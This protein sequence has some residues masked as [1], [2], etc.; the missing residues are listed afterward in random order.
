MENAEQAIRDLIEQNRVLSQQQSDL[1]ARF[2]Q[3]GA[4]IQQ[5]QTE[6]QQQRAADVRVRGVGDRPVGGIDTRNLGKPEI[7]NGEAAK[8]RDWSL[9]L[10]SY[11]SAVDHN[12]VALMNRAE[13]SPNPVLNL[14]LDAAAAAISAQLYYVLVMTCRGTA[15]DRVV[16]AGH[17]EGLEAWRQLQLANDPRTGTRH[18]GML[19]E[20]LSYSFEGDVL[21]RLEA[22][23]RDLA[24][25]ETS[26]G[27]RMPAG[28]KIGTVVRQSPEGALRQ[29]LIMNMDRFQTWEAFKHEIQNVKRAQA[30]AQS[31]PMPMNIDSLQQADPEALQGIANQLLSLAKGKGKTK[32]KKG[33]GKGK[34]KGNQSGS[35]CPICNRSGHTRSE[36][37]Y[38]TAGQSHPQ[39]S[40]SKGKGKGGGGKGK[41]KG[42]DSRQCWTCGQAG[43]VASQCP[44]RGSNL[45]QVGY[46][47]G[48]QN[49]Y[50]SPQQ[51]AQQQQPDP[52]A[53]NPLPYA[54][55][56]PPYIQHAGNPLHAV[57][58]H[59]ASPQAASP[60]H[61]AATPPGMNYAHTYAPSTQGLYLTSLDRD[62]AIMGS[63]MPAGG[64]PG[65][66]SDPRGGQRFSI[67]IDSGAAAS[68]LPSALCSDY[69]VNRLAPGTGDTFR[70]ATGQAVIDQG[71]TN[72][73]V[74]TN[75]EVRG[76]NM[77]RL[78]TSKPLLSVYDMCKAGQ[79]VVF[80]IA[81]NG[82]DMSHSVC[83]HSGKVTR[84][85]LRNNV[86]DLD[87][88]A[89][90]FNASKL[91]AS[92]DSTRYLCPFPGQ[93]QP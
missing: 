70:S 61:P 32:G 52:Y 80:E 7:F 72:I 68:A 12:A 6:L 81:D 35:P 50:E 19:L 65:P 79:K 24:K 82:A 25:Y 76:L 39:H 36:C 88:T 41:G 27:E 75:G 71:S 64:G 86:W 57:T 26:T 55:N 93:A 28:I 21:A 22:F 48:A 47:V 37:W 4:T 34:Q 8:W 18:A 74:S 43:H 1:A 17:S 14:T 92:N 69:P 2:D 77:R 44:R 91:Y 59:A 30:A 31:G 3:A 63:V 90:P 78:E 73:I 33:K 53:V 58:P 49:W 83:R 29:H 42:G 40:P 10:R 11:I 87:V 67:G 38:Q 5:L 20:L 85:T 62:D 66:R 46:D 54:A 23:E 84:F 13:V 9:V 56:P 89:I 60:L 16:N 15:L 45:H 51:P